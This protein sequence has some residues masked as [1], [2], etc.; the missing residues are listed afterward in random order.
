MKGHVFINSFKTMG[1]G[2]FVGLENAWS[3]LFL[4]H[5]AHSVFKKRHFKV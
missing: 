4:R 2:F 3:V 1:C 5:L